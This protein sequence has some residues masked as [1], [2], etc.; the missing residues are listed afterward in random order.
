M[1]RFTSQSVTYTSAIQFLDAHETYEDFIAEHP[2]GE[3]GDAHLVGTHLYSWNPETEEWID[4]GEWVGPQ[5]ETGPTGPTGA[6]GPT[7]PQGIQGETG[8]QG[9]QGETGPQGIQGET[10]PTG[11]DAPTLTETSFAV[12]GGTT[13]TQPTFSGDPLFSGSYVRSGPQV[14]FQV[15]VDFDN[16]TSFGTGQYYVDLP[17]PAKYAY[18]FTAGC[19]HDISTGRDF[20]ITGHVGAGQSQMLLKVLDNQ[21]SL[22]YAVPFT[23]TQPFTLNAADNF[24]I[25]GIY[26]TNEAL[27]S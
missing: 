24:H 2:T 10:G 7:G 13:G 5:G 12:N 22:T 17:F 4:A 25:A 18:E 8:P 26:V 9:I 11:A 16:I 15:Q 23:G 27:G 6:T 19:L 20:A 3:A 14:H 21:G 1:A